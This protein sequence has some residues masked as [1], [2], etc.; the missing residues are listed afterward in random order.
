MLEDTQAAV[1]VRLKG[2]WWHASWRAE[3]GQAGRSGWQ[4]NSPIWII[5]LE[6]G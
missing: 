4:N 2:A 6:G 1:F 3:V 5:E